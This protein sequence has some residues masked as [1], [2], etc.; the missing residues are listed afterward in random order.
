M[1]P[2]H[3]SFARRMQGMALTDQR[4]GILQRW[5]SKESDDQQEQDVQL[6]RAIDFFLVAKKAEG[7]ADQ[8]IS[9]YAQALYHFAKAMPEVGEAEDIDRNVARAYI[10]KLQELEWADRTITSRITHMR[11][12]CNWMVAEGIVRTSPFGRG[13]VPIPTFHRKDMQ[14]ITDDEF[15]SL[16]AVCDARTATGRRDIA[17][18]MFLMDTG[19]RVSEAVGL[20]LSDVNLPQRTA[21]LRRTK[22]RR[23]RTIFFS[24]DTALALTRYVGRR[25]K[26]DGP[27]FIA[28][29][30]RGFESLTPAA[31]RL[32]LDT[33]AKKASLDPRRVHPHAFRHSMATNYL[34]EG[35]DPA[36]LQAM[37]GHADVSTTVRN[38]AHLVTADLQK[39]HD[40]FNS[41]ERITRHKR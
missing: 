34:R 14:T 9:T 30:N 32:R 15:R 31:F 11:T 1:L 17:M 26:Q 40:Q 7:R 37:L 21:Q 23:E 22:S 28:L 36:S 8:T 5:Q 38:Y 10:A 39:K 13:K 18:L 19:V 29:R 25:K 16:L 20:S 33:L 12:F 41:M 24:V 2:A 27:L 6:D 4:P 3:Q 35:G